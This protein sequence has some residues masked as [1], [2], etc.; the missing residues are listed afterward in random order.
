VR[1]AL[2][3]QIFAIQAGGGISRRF[4]ELAM[5]LNAGVVSDIELLP[6]Q[7]PIVNRYVL[8]DDGLCRSMSVRSAR[9]PWTALAAY[10]SYVGQQPAA[11]IVHSTFYLPNGLRR[12]RV[13][14]HV[15]S[16]HDM[17]PELMPSTRRRLDFLTL[18]ERY[19]RAADQLICISEST[20]R[21]LFRVYGKIE[22]PVHVVHLGVSPHFRPGV[23][24][25]DFL[26]ERYILFV[27]HRHQYKDAEILFRA[28]AEVARTDHEV[29]LLCVG[30]N[31]LSNQEGS[32]LEELGIRRRV[33]QR[34]L[35]DDLMPT[36]Y[37]NAELFVFPSR[38]EGFGLPALEAM[39]SG[40]P[41]IL[42]RSTSLPE[43][44]GDG[45]LYFAPGEIPE[46]ADC[47]NAVLTDASLSRS[48]SESGL[49]RA[50]TFTWRR[51]AQRTAEVYREA[52]R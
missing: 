8:D 2:D 29:E 13:G 48:L 39:A 37:A 35:S 6:F 5:Q 17:I 9:N 40:T 19:I 36:T 43:I 42:A 3:E 12:R 30:G 14:K 20:K 46:L 10:F 27:G 44:G 31:G 16:V 23:Q 22:A 21:D 47:I 38:F 25:A 15:V 18:K 32:M 28:F 52:V 51:N 7:S 26:P 24:R 45:A 34:F 4:S 33:S 41:T 49:E 11:D 50:R 1:V